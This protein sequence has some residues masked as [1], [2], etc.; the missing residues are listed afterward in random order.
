MPCASGVEL[1][2][3]AVGQYERARGGG[4]GGTGGSGG[5]AGPG[6]GGGSGAQVGGDAPR[7]QARLPFLGTVQQLPHFST[8]SERAGTQTASR[9]GW[10]AAL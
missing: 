2:Q 9:H 6:D 3:P 5:G 8:H 4:G 1:C 7:R 10:G